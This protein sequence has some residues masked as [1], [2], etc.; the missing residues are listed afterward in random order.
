MQKVPVLEIWN[1]AILSL[2][3]KTPITHLTG[4]RELEEEI[5]Y[6]I[7]DPGAQCMLQIHLIAL[8]DVVWELGPPPCHHPVGTAET[9]HHSSK[10]T[11]ASHILH[12]IPIIHTD[13]N[14]PCHSKSTIFHKTSYLLLWTSMEP[15]EGVLARTCAVE[16]C[17]KCWLWSSRLWCCVD[18]QVAINILYECTA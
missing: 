11:H 12:L 17:C 13:I 2:L 15:S 9:V 1:T 3:S 6:S 5:E 7:W 8:D 10:T 18:L 14:Q 16:H 4:E